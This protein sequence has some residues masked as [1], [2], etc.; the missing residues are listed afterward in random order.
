M[1]WRLARFLL[2]HPDPMADAVQGAADLSVSEDH[3]ATRRIASLAL[4]DIFL[5]RR[6][7]N[8]PTT[9]GTHFPAL[10]VDDVRKVIGAGGRERSMLPLGG[11]FYEKKFEGP[12]GIVVDVGH[13]AGAAPVGD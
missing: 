6:E 7:W 12:E 4:A 2:A 3:P 10:R 1:A 11:S 5:L 8:D 13:W 9:P